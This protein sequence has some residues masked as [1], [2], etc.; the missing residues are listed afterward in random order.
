MKGLE[1]MLANLI[2]LKPEEMKAQVAEGIGFM[3][4][5]AKAMQQIQKDLELIKNHLGISDNGTETIINGGR[6][7]TERR[8]SADSNRIQL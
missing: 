3:E 6:Q 2:G 7:L 5:G 4:H 8:D 1:M